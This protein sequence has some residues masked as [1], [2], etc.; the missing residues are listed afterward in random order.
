[1]FRE[2]VRVP[3]PRRAALALG[4]WL[5]S[6]GRR[7]TGFFEHAPQSYGRPTGLP[8]EPPVDAPR[9]GAE[10]HQD[11]FGPKSGSA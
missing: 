4:I 6:L 7:A 5:R 2:R 9:I 8:G 1:V 10:R 3:R 11:P